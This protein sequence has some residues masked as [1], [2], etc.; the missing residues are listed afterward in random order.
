VLVDGAVIPEPSAVAGI[1][2]V[3]VLGF[4]V[5]LRRRSRRQN[6]PKA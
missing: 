6:H 2:G 3:T 5:M 1:F 4:T